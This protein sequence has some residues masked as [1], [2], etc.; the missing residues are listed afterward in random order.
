MKRNSSLSQ[1]PQG[2]AILE[3]DAQTQVSL[4]GRHLDC[5][6]LRPAAKP[7]SNS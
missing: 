5:N 1:Q 2:R 7:A 6:L 4:T 3:T